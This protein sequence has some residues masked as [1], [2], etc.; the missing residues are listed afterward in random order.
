MERKTENSKVIKATKEKLYGAFTEPN[1]LETW[2]VP[3]EM[4]GKI[5]SFD[6]SIGGGYEMSL[7]YPDSD[8]ESKGKTQG[9]E[10]RYKARFVELKP[11]EKIVQNIIFDTEDAAMKGEMKMSVHLE[12]VENATK[13]TIAF[14]NIPIGI[15]LK[16]NEEGTESSL[17]KLAEFVE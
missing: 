6:L 9:K 17:Q 10:D 14:D 3:G 4:T 15:G 2:L 12:S 16:D 5:H 8:K 1:A 7:F 13:V 11:F